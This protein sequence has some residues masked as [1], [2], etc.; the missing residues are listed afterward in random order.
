MNKRAWWASIGRTLVKNLLLGMCMERRDAGEGRTVKWQD[1]SLPKMPWK[2]HP[3]KHHLCR[4]SK[5]RLCGGY[6]SPQ[7]CARYSCFLTGGAF[8]PLE[9]E[10]AFS[11]A[12]CTDR[13]ISAFFYPIQ[14]QVPISP[15]PLSLMELPVWPPAVPSLDFCQMLLVM[16]FGSW[17]TCLFL[18]KYQIL[19]K[20][21]LTG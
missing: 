10:R 3:A 18:A 19:I 7:C 1:N 21:V 16:C 11:R 15:V 4:V 5:C 12:F 14:G 17:T 9:N 6:V 20:I 13:G 2:D 8:L